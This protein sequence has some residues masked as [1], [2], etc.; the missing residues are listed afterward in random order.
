MTSLE[1][2]D[3]RSIFHPFTSIAEHRKVG[4]IVMVGGEGACLRDT[5][6]REYIDGLAG[7][8]CVD[9]GY[10]RN[11]VAEAIARQA[12]EL[13]YYHSFFSMS[14]QPSIELADRLQKLAPWPVSRVFFGLSGSD[15]NDTQFKL[16]WLYQKLRGQPGKRKIIARERGYHGITIAAASA[17]GLPAVHE[18]FGLPLDGFV[19]VRA[20]YPYREMKEG[21]TESDFVAELAADLDAAILHSLANT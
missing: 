18:A 4:P 15:A 17:T 20:P 2:I 19:H 5:H 10:G 9:I 7:L 12:R 14:N 3:Q 11:E 1:E 6:G 8:W 13:P 16:V 21:Q